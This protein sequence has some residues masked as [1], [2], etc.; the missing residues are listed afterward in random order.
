MRAASFFVGATAPATAVA[1]IEPAEDDD[2][3]NLGLII[4]IIIVVA[5]IGGGIALF[6]IR[7]RRTV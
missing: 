2:G 1:T 5:L 6:T 4:G 3:G 7:S